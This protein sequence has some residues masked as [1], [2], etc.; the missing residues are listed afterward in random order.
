MK[1]TQTQAYQ[2]PK[3]SNSTSLFK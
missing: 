3:H 1:R 2:D